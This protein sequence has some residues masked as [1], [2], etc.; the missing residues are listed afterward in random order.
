MEPSLKSKVAKD[1]RSELN[2]AA[3]LKRVRQEDQ[4]VEMPA[5][6]AYAFAK[7][8]TALVAGRFKYTAPA[9][10]AKASKGTATTT[11]RCSPSRASPTR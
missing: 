5:A 4:F 9:A 2:R 1:S 8:D 6:K 7:A 3:F 10:A 11:R